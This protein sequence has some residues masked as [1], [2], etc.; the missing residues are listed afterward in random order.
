[1]V[2]SVKSK[3]QIQDVFFCELSWYKKNQI[4][5]IQI[6]VF[7]ALYIDL[8][9]GNHWKHGLVLG[10]QAPILGI[11]GASALAETSGGTNPFSHNH[12]VGGFNPFEKYWSKWES[13]Q[14]R[15]EKKKMKPPPS[16]LNS[17]KPN[18]KVAVFF[19]VSPL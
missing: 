2:N 11:R 18:L 4:T 8:R 13:S 3:K 15:G 6:Q 7:Q 9:L 12:L 17:N 16:H 14:N 19:Q 1:M 5:L 10:R